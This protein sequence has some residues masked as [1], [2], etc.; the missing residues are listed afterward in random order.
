MLQPAGHRDPSS[1]RQVLAN[2]Q[3]VIAGS[4]GTP[5]SLD[6]LSLPA[7]CMQHI[8][9]QAEPWDRTGLECDP[10][11]TEA[12]SLSAWEGHLGGSPL[13][14]DGAIKALGWFLIKT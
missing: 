4:W 10:A 3:P 6:E 1:Q 13:S 7:L 8:R 11:Q 5:D 14:R 2:A 9:N 12:I